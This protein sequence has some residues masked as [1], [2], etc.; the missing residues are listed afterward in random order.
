MVDAIQTLFVPMMGSPMQ[1]DVNARQ[2]SQTRVQAQ[3]LFARVSS[4][5]K[6]YQTDRARRI[7]PV[8]CF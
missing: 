4:V 5:A 7:A 3:M 8:Y 1:C 2:V 6:V